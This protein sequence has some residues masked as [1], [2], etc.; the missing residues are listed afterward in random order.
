MGYSIHI[1]NANDGSWVELPQKHNFAGQTYCVGGTTEAWM[2]ITYNYWPLFHKYIDRGD[3]IRFIYGKSL[4]EADAILNNAIEGIKN[5][6]PE[7]FQE[8]P[9][10]AGNPWECTPYNVLV[11]L[12]GLQGIGEQAMK[13]YPDT[14]MI[15]DG[16]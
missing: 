16:D 8:E 11:A 10:G 7:V 1:K 2:S 12:M 13:A 4:K 6:S 15:W 3:G 5:D 9:P 14:E